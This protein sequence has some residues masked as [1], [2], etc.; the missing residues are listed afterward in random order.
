MMRFVPLKRNKA[1]SEENVEII[2]DVNEL[3]WFIPSNKPKNSNSFN[4]FKR[5]AKTSLTQIETQTIYFVNLNDKVCGFIQ[6]LYSNVMSGIYKGF[7]L[8]LKIFT[9]IPNDSRNKELEV[10]ETIKLD[11][12]KFD[13]NNLTVRG[14]NFDYEIKAFTTTK[15]NQFNLGLITINIILSQLE[16]KLKLHLGEG[17]RISPGGC[18]Y[19]LDKKIDPS[20]LDSLSTN[21]KLKKYMR[22]QFVPI[23][24]C[25]GTIKYFTDRKGK[26]VSEDKLKEGTNKL[27]L[28]EVPILYIDAV[29]G[30]LP[31]KAAKRWNFLYFQSEAYCIQILEYLTTKSYDSV[32]VT[33]WSITQNDKII[34]KNC[35]INND[36][37]VQIIDT[38]IDQENKF[39]I[40]T[41]VKFKFTETDEIIISELNLVNRY[42]ILGEFPHIVKKLANEIINLKPYLYQY[43]QECEFN[44]EKGISIYETSFVS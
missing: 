16:I 5:E 30:L 17:F 2:K 11:N 4:L 29:Q 22:H 43:C 18:S 6:I 25:E 37:I 38:K 24:K 35:E 7:Q 8:N 41:K 12:I 15:R 39:N 32:K 36:N 31:N 20:E 26:T 21:R 33:I 10:W 28:Q 27:V 3:A 40:P 19:Y 23:G 9:P 1:P 13:D 34:S 14:K 44:G 42:D